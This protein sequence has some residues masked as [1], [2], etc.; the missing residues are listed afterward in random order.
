[1]GDRVFLQPVQAPSLERRQLRRRLQRT[2]GILESH[3]EVFGVLKF[4]INE[5]SNYVTGQ[6]IFVDGGFSIW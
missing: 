4:L 2:S 5:E 3:S 6:N 1:M